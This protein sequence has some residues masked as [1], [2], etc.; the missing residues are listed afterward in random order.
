MENPLGDIDAYAIH[1][2]DPRL[3]SAAIMPH[4][5]AMEE[6]MLVLMPALSACTKQL[7]EE[8]NVFGRIYSTAST[9]FRTPHALILNMGLSDSYA[10][11]SHGDGGDTAWC[12]AFSGKCPENAQGP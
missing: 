12:I 11:P 6:R 10:S 1:F 7:V 5:A 8:A 3:D 9:Q 4:V 2:D